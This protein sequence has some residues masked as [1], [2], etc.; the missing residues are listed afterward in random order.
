MD[1]EFSKVL[2]SAPIKKRPRKRNFKDV[3]IEA[4]L[5]H[6]HGSKRSLFVTEDFTKEGG[7]LETKHYQETL[8]QICCH[9]L[10]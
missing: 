3:E 6:S 9:C 1:P 4:N 8:M 5:G 10:D 7:Q 2:L